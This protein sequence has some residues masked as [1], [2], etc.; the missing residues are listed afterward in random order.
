VNASAIEIEK[1]ARIEAQTRRAWQEYHERVRF[2]HG[3]EYIAAEDASWL[4]LQDRLSA[5]EQH[6][7]L[8]HARLREHR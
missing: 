8:L 7:R 5:L 2:L 6:R 4:E 3:D 1:L